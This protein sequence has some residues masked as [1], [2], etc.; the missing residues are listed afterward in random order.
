MATLDTLEARY[1]GTN[2]GLGKG[3]DK[4]RVGHG[5]SWGLGIFRVILNFGMF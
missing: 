3:G 1:N 5:K 2:P 4:V